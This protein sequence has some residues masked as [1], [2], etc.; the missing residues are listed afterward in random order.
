MHERHVVFGLGPVGLSVVAALRARGCPVRAVTSR[1]VRPP[2]LS[3]EV[4]VARADLRDPTQAIA[5]AEGA[6]HVYQCTNARAYHRWAEEFPPLQHGAVVA[7]RAAGAVLVVV[8]NLYVYGPHGGVPMHEA[9]PLEGRGLR[10]SPRVAMTRELDALAGE[11]R[12]VRA[13]ASDLFGPGV[14][15][16][17]V[18][19]A[20]FEAVLRGDD[21]VF[22][23]GDV[24]LAHSITFA[25]DLGRALAML[26]RDERAWG[27][28]W[29]APSPPGVTP[30]ELVRLACEVVG[31][32]RPPRL[33]GLS[34]ALANVVLPVVG[35]VTPPLRGL[36]EHLSMFYEPFVVDDRRCVETFGF[37]STALEEA[38]RQ[39]L[40]SLRA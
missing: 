23:F 18:G 40:H 34:R 26:A 15:A 32:A 1:G 29:H 17:A 16:S 35:L 7:A 2:T 22:F 25:P 14:R 13:R 30:R 20:L 33:R 4:V 12:V 39:T 19:A 6:T 38:L 11:L 36:R 28:V 10:A 21:A 8:E 3:P 37:Q 27:K 31:R 5:A 24:Y 9:L